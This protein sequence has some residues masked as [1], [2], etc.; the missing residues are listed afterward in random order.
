VRFGAGT[1]FPVADLALSTLT[2]PASVLPEGMTS[3]ALA[4]DG[5]PR[6]AWVPGRD[7]RMVTDLGEPR[8]IGAVVTSWTRRGAPDAVVS[9]SDDGLTFTDVGQVPRTGVVDVARTARYV[10]VTTSWRP[11]DPALTA[12]RV[13]PPGD[14]GSA[15]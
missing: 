4:V 15:S 10:A 5:D 3:P 13:L 11:G 7:G 1:P 2:F 14:S 12:L 9:V 8:E 6:T